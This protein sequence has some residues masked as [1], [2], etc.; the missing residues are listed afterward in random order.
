MKKTIL[1]LLGKRSFL[2]LNSRISKSNIFY[3]ALIL[4]FTGC[5]TGKHYFHVEM[6]VEELPTIA[7]PHEVRVYANGEAAP[8]SSQ[9]I[10]EVWT[11]HDITAKRQAY[12]STL[13]VIREAVSVVGGNGFYIMEHRK[14]N[15]IETTSHDLYGMVLLTKDS[16]IYS[17]TDNPF[18]KRYAEY[19]KELNRHRVNPH[20][21]HLDA[22]VSFFKNN[23]TIT[24]EGNPLLNDALKRGVSLNASYKYLV[25]Y[26][27]YGFG[28]VYNN[29]YASASIVE[30]SDGMKSNCSVNSIVHSII[31]TITWYGCS[32]RILLSASFGI[33]NMWSIYYWNYDEPTRHDKKIVK[34]S[35]ALYSSVECEYRITHNL[36]ISGHFYLNESPDSNRDENPDVSNFGVSIGLNYHL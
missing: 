13:A 7:S 9:I 5:N 34:P 14:P 11:E 33:G 23:L 26:S 32:Q 6:K 24:E 4:L 2:G 30:R 25:P 28:V 15:Y 29:H 19:N 36:G 35:P 20:H 17:R 3:V 10:G 21:L 16:T 12:D 31:P 27:L 18:S 8:D 22:G 1:S